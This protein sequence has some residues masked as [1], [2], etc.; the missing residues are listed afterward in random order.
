MKVK[1]AGTVLIDLQNK[2]IGLIYREKD[3]SYSFPKGHLEVGETLQEC[4]V[5]E[6]EEETGRKNYLISEEEL[7][8]I[9]YITQ[10]GEEVENYMYIAIDD[11][12]TEKNI[13]IELQ[14]KLEWVSFEEIE[15][16][17]I[18]DSL[19]VFWKKIKEKIKFIIENSV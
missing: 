4:A 2:K 11:G 3:K 9:Q 13:P 6:T 15:E 12:Q 18:Y 16:K 14:E 10:N 19:K 5:R 17:L 7:E 1:K 8:V